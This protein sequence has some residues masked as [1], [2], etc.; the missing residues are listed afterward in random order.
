VTAPASIPAL[1][2]EGRRLI[3]EATP[4]PVRAGRSDMI[5]YGV[6]DDRPYKNIYVGAATARRARNDVPDD[7]AKVWGVNCIADATLFAFAVNALPALL[8]VVEAA[9]RNSWA[10]E[11]YG[12][13]SGASHA[14][15]G[16]IC[17]TCER[18]KDAAQA[19]LDSEDALDSAL[20]RLR[21]VR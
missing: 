7:L 2:A 1:I 8:D 4:G 14:E 18:T 3:A 9:A 20:S 13:A 11:E 6:D 21:G 16:S 12:L 17:E 5:S 10:R 19:V 15:P